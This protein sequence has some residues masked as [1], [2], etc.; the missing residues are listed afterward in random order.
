MLDTLIF[1]YSALRRSHLESHI[2]VDEAYTE[3]GENDIDAMPFETKL[4]KALGIRSE[5]REMAQAL[6][7]KNKH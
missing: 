5:F 6:H 4:T 7:G 1:E 3:P 2:P